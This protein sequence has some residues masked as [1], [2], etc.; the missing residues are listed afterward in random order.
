M[1]DILAEI[2]F[3]ALAELLHTLD[4][5]VTFVRTAKG[6]KAGHQP[7][8]GLSMDASHVRWELL[9]SESLYHTV[10]LRT[11][12]SCA[13]NCSFCS[14]VANQGPLTLKSPDTLR[15]ELVALTTAHPHVRSVIFTDDT[16]NVPRRRFVELCRVLEDFGLEAERGG[17][18]FAGY[19]ERFGIESTG[20]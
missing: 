20:R 12:R 6:M 8:Q 15:T 11:A 9:E 13:F 18:R 2:A 16:F 17:D 14:Y 3:N 1:A 5:P 4:I 10:H 7:E 19:C